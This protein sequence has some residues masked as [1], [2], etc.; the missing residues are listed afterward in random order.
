VIELGEEDDPAATAR[1]LAKRAEV[2]G[3]CG[4]DGTM[5]AAA[6]AAFEAGLPLL[7]FPGGTMNHL[8]RDL[9]IEGADDA[10]R[11]LAAGEAARIDVASVDGSVFVNNATLGAHVELVESRRRLAEKTGRWPAQALAA[12]RALLKSEPV[13]VRLDGKPRELW[14]G[15]FGNGTYHDRGIAPGWRRSLDS[16]VLDVRL[17]EA[18]GGRSRARG[19]L[20]LLLAGTGRDRD[21][22]RAEVR[23]LRLEPLEG[24]LRVTRDGE[25]IE[26]EEPVLIASHR[27]ALLAYSPAG[28][29]AGGA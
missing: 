17:L 2:L 13:H 12:A 28:G 1:R 5:A 27:G 4:G 16:G 9:G 25:M 15:F 8:A 21:L 24:P 19:L 3:V 7:V 29:L 11:A 6:Q 20:A 22:R 10:V 23:S 18:T 14:L 26:T